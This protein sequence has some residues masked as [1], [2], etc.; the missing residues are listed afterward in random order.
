MLIL[1]RINGFVLQNRG[2]FNFIGNI[3]LIKF[4]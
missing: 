3:P 4:R 1:K 2:L